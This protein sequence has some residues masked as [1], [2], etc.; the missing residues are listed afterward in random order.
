MDECL[1]GNFFQISNLCYTSQIHYRIAREKSNDYKDDG[2][3]LLC[4]QLL[5]CWFSHD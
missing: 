3:W 5:Y 4:Y 1:F 2:G